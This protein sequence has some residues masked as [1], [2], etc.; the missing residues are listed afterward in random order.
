[1]TFSPVENQRNRTFVVRLTQG[2]PLDPRVLL[3]DLGFNAAGMVQLLPA[4]E[5][6]GD[7]LRSSG[8]MPAHRAERHVAV[9][10]VQSLLIVDDH[11]L[12]CDALALT[13]KMAFGLRKTRI[14][15]TLAS[16]VESIRTDGAADAIV[17]DLNLP[18]S[19][20][21][22]GLV[23]LLRMAPDV[24]ITLI[25]ADPD[26]AVIG[27]ALDAGAQGFVCKSLSRE[28]LIEAFSRMW[29]GEIVVPENYDPTRRDAPDG[30]V[31]LMRRFGTLT[32][33]QM[34]I[35]RLICHGKAN[36]EI[37]YE[38]SIAEA[39]VKTH[40]TAILSKIDARRRT[41]A[42]LLAHLAHLF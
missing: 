3:A 16:A 37:S 39:T 24:P 13:L 1:M 35:L 14:A 4:N 2:I 17:L 6:E 22:E 5:R 26:P 33:Q 38:L 30:Q 27:A 7:D 41:Q 28:A 19:A 9:P 42:V 40:I 8:S 23:T 29:A 36:K 21:T 20:G 11:P 25:S 34:R 31:E 15:R 32:P 12:M 18:D 10:A